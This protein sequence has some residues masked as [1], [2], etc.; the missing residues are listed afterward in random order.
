VG[1]TSTVLVEVVV[2]VVA[3]GVPDA[4]GAS[5]V[6]DVSV[7]VV[8]SFFWQPAVRAAPRSRTAA[9]LRV[10][11]MMPPQKRR[12]IGPHDS[13]LQQACPGMYSARKNPRRVREDFAGD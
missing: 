13:E 3:S 6:V 2:D 12:P 8:A 1:V 11:F 7:V 4:F 9:S 5:R 10:L